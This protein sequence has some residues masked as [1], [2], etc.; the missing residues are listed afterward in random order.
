MN[1]EESFSNEGDWRGAFPRFTGDNFNANM[2]LVNQFKALADKKAAH[3]L[4]WQSP[5]C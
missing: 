5:G 2:K 3:T 4:S 1:N